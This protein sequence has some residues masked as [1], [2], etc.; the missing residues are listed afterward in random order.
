MFID[1]CCKHPRILWIKKQLGNKTIQPP[2][3]NV[4]FKTLPSWLLVFSMACTD[5]RMWQYPSCLNKWQFEAR[6]CGVSADAI[7]LHVC[8]ASVQLYSMRSR[9]TVIWVLSTLSISAAEPGGHK[10]IVMKP[11]P[12][13]LFDFQCMAPCSRK[14][15]QVHTPIC[16]QHCIRHS[17]HLTCD[18]CI[19]IIWFG[20][21]LVPSHGIFLGTSQSLRWSWPVACHD[22][23]E[24]SLCCDHNMFLQ[25]ELANMKYH[26]PHLSTDGYNELLMKRCRSPIPVV[27]FLSSDQSTTQMFLSDWNDWGQSSY[28]ETFTSSVT[29]VDD[30]EWHSGSPRGIKDRAVV[31]MSE[32]KVPC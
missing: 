10:L 1:S 22:N 30:L 7:C 27:K 8:C 11:A 29:T 17:K 31:F 5:T 32:S 28:L 15:F 24:D 18:T 6:D 3:L 2:A 14:H 23:Y 21:Y 9:S 4:W 16:S 26:L 25:T 13:T 19:H 20:L 12:C